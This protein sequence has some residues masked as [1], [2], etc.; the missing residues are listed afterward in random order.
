METN[1]INHDGRRFLDVDLVQF[2]QKDQ[3]FYI[4][5]IKAKDFLEI[6]TV[7]P[8]QY[9]LMKHTALA[10]SFPDDKE[11]Y[12]FLISEDRENIKH[13][14]FQRDADGGRVNQIARFLNEEEYAFFPNTIIANCEL[15]NDSK[16][17]VITENSH[18]IDFLNVEDKPEYIS[19]LR[20]EDEQ[21]KLTIPIKEN[22]ILIID[23]QHRL[24]GLAECE[25]DVQE[26][27]DLLIAFIISFDRSVIAQQFYTINYEQKPVNKSLL[28]QL[29]GEFSRDVNELSFMHNVV[30]LLNELA[31]SP[32][33]G[34][35]KML[36]VTPKDLDPD[37]K[38]KL[39]ISQ[40]FLVD[41][42]IRYVSIKA[43]NTTYPPIFLKYYQKPEEHITIVRSIARFFNA[44]RELKPDWSTPENSLLS[45]GMGV[46]ALLKVYNLLFPIIFCEEMMLSWDA[47]TKLEIADYKRILSGIEN[48][49]FS[50]EGE[51]GKTGSAGS[52]NKIK[53]TIIKKLTYLND[54]DSYQA[55]ENSYKINYLPRF[56]AALENLKKAGQLK[57]TF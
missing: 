25:I 5:K 30:K 26:T 4:G 8:A 18:L 24:K 47:I 42:M 43:M 39:S 41:S 50:S 17:F 56:N 40:A 27:Y 22:S 54:P 13:K 34:R 19:F 48:V 29:T 36:G 2:I 33:H 57:L 14:D 16:E 3:P 52:V 7:R 9:D 37:A 20:K 15:I 55:F 38:Q 12:D 49:D 6:Y 35:V 45:K 10:E 32:F 51:F 31:E 1:I 23:G 21:Y 11:Y 44:V 46:G 53:E 28:Y